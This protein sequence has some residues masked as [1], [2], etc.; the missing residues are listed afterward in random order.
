MAVDLYDLFFAGRIIQG[1]D[2]Q[3]VRNAI[4]RLFSADD[5][6][7]ERLFSGTSVKIKSSID[8]DT[9]IQY[10]VA[11]R[12]AGALL[13]IRPIA[14]TGPTTPPPGDAPAEQAESTE[15][16]LLPPMTGTLLECAVPVDPAPIPDISAITLAPQGTPIDESRPAPA[17]VLNTDDLTLAPAASGTLEDCRVVPEPEPLPDI[18][19]MKLVD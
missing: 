8:Q 5:Q 10:R 18:S 19:G 4:A 7:L 3:Q 15:L 12:D 1:K 11:F 2:P 17:P 14:A 16:Q 13:D 6:A 9:A